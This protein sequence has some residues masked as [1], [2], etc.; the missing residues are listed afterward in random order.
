MFLLSSRIIPLEPSLAEADLLATTRTPRN[1]VERKIRRRNLAAETSAALTVI[2]SLLILIFPTWGETLPSGTELTIRLDQDLRPSDKNSKDSKNS[3][4]F[5]APLAFPVFAN[6]REILPAGSKVEGEIRGTKK[7]IFLSPRRLILPDGRQLDFNAIVSAIDQK[8]LKA[9]EKEGT[10]EAKGGNKGEI[11]QQAGEI[12]STG[13]VIGALSTYTWEGMAIGA[14][15][16]VAAVLIGHK[17]AGGKD[18]SVIPAGTQLTLDLNQPLEVPDD[19]AEAKPSEDQPLNR[20]D[21][22]P[23]LR[24]QDAPDA[25][26]P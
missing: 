3:Q 23:T 10:I 5:S 1:A 14:A 19:S 11:A 6:G 15:A 12:G 2:L 17:I 18:T 16:G 7:A 26:T 21:R 24:R 9:E 4:K 25:D 8:H 22:R 20:E 13:A